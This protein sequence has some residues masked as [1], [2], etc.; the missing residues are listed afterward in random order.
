M[1][2]ELVALHGDEDKGIDGNAN[3]Y[4]LDERRELTESLPQDP[5][6][7]Q[8]VD[9]GDWQADDAH[10]DVRTRK[11]HDEDVGNVAHLLVPRDDEHQAGVPDE[12]HGHDGAVSDDEERGAAH[13]RR[14]F[15]C[16]IPW[17]LFPQ[18]LVVIGVLLQL[19][20]GLTRKAWD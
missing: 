18:G 17:Y 3:R 1:D 8:S 9:N 14:T 15:L 13:G 2:N 6:V 12:A 19:H 4:A 10:E 5:V 16:E 7:H 20:D 11:V